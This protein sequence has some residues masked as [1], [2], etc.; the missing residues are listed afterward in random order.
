MADNDATAQG[1]SGGPHSRTVSLHHLR[2]RSTNERIHEIL[3]VRPTPWDALSLPMVAIGDPAELTMDEQ[4]ARDR[5]EGM[6]PDSVPVVSADEMTGIVARGPGLK[7]Q[8]V[9]PGGSSIR[10]R[11]SIYGRQPLSE[12]DE[13]PPPPSRPQQRRPQ[14][15]QQAGVS[16]ADGDGA[17]TPWWR[18]SLGKFQSVEL[19]NKGSVARDHL[20]LERTFLAW[21]RT[22]LAFASIGIA[23][24]QLFRLNTSLSEETGDANG[25]TLRRMG[26]PL[27]AAFLAV[28]I[29]T[30]L[31]G[32]RRYF[33]G[34]EWVMRGK[35]PASRGTIIVI[36]F[37]ALA[38]ML[39]SLVV[40]I[41][42]HPSE[43]GEA[44]DL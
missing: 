29:L 13:E 38:I 34:Q 23:V 20:A 12:D 32:F 28:S 27:G 8:A 3:E 39:V 5:A 37:L 7:Y 17:H 40:V 11:R 19:E 6:G 33:R 4:T 18:K 10:S 9:Q 26:K 15:Q 36:A 14:Q 2:R 16:G 21:L 41:V 25:A 24:T 31:L 30:L 1:S 42:I 22:S 44:E 35:F 43:T